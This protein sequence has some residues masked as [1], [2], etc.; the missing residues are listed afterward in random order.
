MGYF[1]GFFYPFSVL[2]VS[3]GIDNRAS[4]RVEIY[5]VNLRFMCVHPHVLRLVFTFSD[6]IGP[7]TGNILLLKSVF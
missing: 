6:S 7:L 3:S 1:I 2:N 5:Y 4:G